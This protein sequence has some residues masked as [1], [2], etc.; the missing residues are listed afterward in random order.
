MRLKA[1]ATILL[2]ILC[3]FLSLEATAR[4]YYFG[5]DGF[6][7]RKMDSFH[8][9]GRS[10]LIQLSKDPAISYELKPNVDG[11]FKMARFV[12]NSQGF[13]DQEYSL[14]KPP[15]TFRVAV[16]GASYVMGSGVEM[17]DTFHA[18]LENQLNRENK[19]MTYEFINMG[20]GGH[21]PWNS[22]A[23]LKKRALKYEPD[24]VIF[25]TTPNM[26]KSRPK[27]PLRIIRPV[28]HPFFDSYFKTLLRLRIAMWQNQLKRAKKPAR[29]AKIKEARKRIDGIFSELKGIEENSGIPVCVVILEHRKNSLDLLKEIQ[30]AARNRV[31]RLIDASEPFFRAGFPE[32]CAHPLDCHPNAA[33]HRVFARVIYDFLLKDH[34][35]EKAGTR[36]A[37]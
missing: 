23:V 20:I 28:S 15:H 32:Y 22:L 35:L 31:V 24:L 5:L 29:D 8:D 33:A 34:L 13:R 6:K 25:G 19:G 10:G 21:S 9:L 7:Y 12:T 2:A 37:S 18:V 11:Y 4:Y 14:S 26:Y 27:P 1:A 3:V 30:A 36:N 17:E 16:V